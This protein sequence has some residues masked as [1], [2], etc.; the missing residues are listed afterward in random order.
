MLSQEHSIAQFSRQP[1]T[2]F[3]SLFNFRTESTPLITATVSPAKAENS[4]PRKSE[5]A[6]SKAASM[7][8]II[9]IFSAILIISATVNPFRVP[10]RDSGPI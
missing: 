2:A 3:E 7:S 9:S 1:L 8:L 10:F 4:Q 6:I 5:T